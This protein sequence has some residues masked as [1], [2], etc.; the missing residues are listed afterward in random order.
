MSERVRLAPG[1]SKE[2]E[3]NAKGS[4]AESTVSPQ[5]IQE[6][7]WAKV[8]LRDEDECWN[9]T[10]S[11]SAKGYGNFR[12]INRT[13]LAHRFILADMNVE[14]ARCPMLACHTCHNRRCVN[15]AHLYWGTAADNSRDMVMAG[16][17]R[18][19]NSG[20]TECVRGHSLTGDN[21][22]YAPKTGQRHCRKCSRIR[23]G[24]DV[25]TGRIR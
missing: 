16:R 11:V 9:W 17:S 5:R 15:P 13:E 21:V 1:Y 6:R 20:V 23:K 19:R 2:E 4:V 24:R 14:V 18:N 3:V 22:Y 25:D 8:D 10:G 7:F 12:V